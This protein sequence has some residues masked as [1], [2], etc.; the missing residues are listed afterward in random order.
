[1]KMLSALAFTALL[2]TS[3]AFAA[4][5]PPTSTSTTG[6][7]APATAA[8]AEKHMSSKACNK[9]ADEKKL[10]GEDRAKFV[11]D[12][13]SGKAAKSGRFVS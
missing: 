2:G 7:A 11:K 4:G 13:H 5:T 6:A 9:Q 8:P 3:A 1:M 12:C 10:T